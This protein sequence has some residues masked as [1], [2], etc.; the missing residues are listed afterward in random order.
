M[1]TAYTFV[2]AREHV[3]PGH[4]E[5]P[6]RFDALEPKLGSFAAEALPVHPATRAEIARIHR[7]ELIDA[8]EAACK[9]GTAIIDPAPTFITPTSFED[10]LSA[11]GATLECTRSVLRGQAHNAFA[12]VRPPGHHA[13]PDRAMGFCLFNNVAIAACDALVRSQISMQRVAIVDFDAH[14]GNGTQAAFR[15]EPRVAYLSTHQWGIYP[16]TGWYTEAPEAKRRIVNVPLPE[17][18]GDTIFQNV[19]DELMTPFLRAFRPDLLLVSAGFDAHWRD[20][21]TTLGLSTTGFYILS[22]RLVELAE[23]LCEG[24]I[25]FVLEGG[26][27]PVNLAN[28]A[29]AVFAALTGSTADQNAQD[30]M[31][32]PEPDSA[33]QQIEQIRKWHGF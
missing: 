4:P 1:T 9:R 2:P 31:P 13:E 7:V 18:S 3:Y 6:S 21:I 19:A 16:G 29:T 20:P 30:R 14:H 8:L 28:G 27:D 23:E 12:L 5:A 24:R 15:D 10:A 17:R 32:Y 11:A 25:V 33:A 22:R 26:Y